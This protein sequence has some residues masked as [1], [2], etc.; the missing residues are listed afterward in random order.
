MTNTFCFRNSDYCDLRRGIKINGSK[1]I[2]IDADRILDLD[3]FIFNE[4]LEELV[5]NTN[6]HALNMRL[7]RL[8]YELKKLT[9]MNAK[10]KNPNKFFHNN[11]NL[12]IEI[13]NCKISGAIKIKPKDK[14]YD[15]YVGRYHFA[16]CDD[17]PK[18]PRR[19]ILTKKIIQYPKTKIRKVK[20]NLILNDF[21]LVKLSDPEPL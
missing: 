4:K 6:N 17:S 12:E 11:Q 10:I 20:H 14:E 7:L 15:E 19:I 16:Y 8:P 18:E 1:R 13:I 2:V 3:R 5:I 9:I 21:S